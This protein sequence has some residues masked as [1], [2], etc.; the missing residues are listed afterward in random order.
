MDIRVKSA[1]A[2]MESNLKRGLKP[3]HL[4]RSVHLS[5]SR[6]RHLFKDETGLSPLQYLNYLKMKRA[7]EL[8]ESSFLSIKEILIEINLNSSSRFALNFKRAYG[9][10]PSA[11]RTL[12]RKNP[13]L[14]TD[15]HIS[16]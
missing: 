6:L 3:N 15:S 7:K 9:L 1:I 8:L 5:R 2:L 14:P 4:S 13:K 12:L 11:Y 16:V 10:T